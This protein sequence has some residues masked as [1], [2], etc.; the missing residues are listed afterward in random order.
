MKCHLLSLLFS[1]CIVSIKAQVKKVPDYTKHEL[2]SEI[3]T[4]YAGSSFDFFSITISK[5]LHC[6]LGGAVAF[7]VGMSKEYLYDS[8]PDKNDL[9]SDFW[10]CCNGMLK[11]RIG[12]DL[13]EKKYPD[14]KYFEFN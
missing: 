8:K 6:V 3:I 7:G 1:F 2:C 14:R 10:G 13:N 5:G 11:L 9:M 12:L 4:G